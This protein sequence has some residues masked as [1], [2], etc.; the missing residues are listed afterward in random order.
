MSVLYSCADWLVAFLFTRLPNLLFFK[1]TYLKKFLNIL[2]VEGEGLS[3]S[4]G[5][6]THILT[7]LLHYVV[8]LLLVK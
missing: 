8:G 7:S 4:H 3:L 6:T 1:T 5:P 2:N